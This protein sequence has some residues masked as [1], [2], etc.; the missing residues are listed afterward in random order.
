[1]NRTDIHRD[2]DGF[3]WD[4]LGAALREEA[5]SELEL[6]RLRRRVRETVGHHDVR[7]PA[8]RAAAVAATFSLV[9]LGLSFLAGSPS[10]SSEPVRLYAERDGRVVIEFADGKVHR[11]KKSTDPRFEKD[12]VVRTAKGRKL[13]DDDGHPA[14]GQVVFYRI[15]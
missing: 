14:P 8:L 11:V 13:V 3:R 4:A 2:A 5:P 7:R 9:A 15:D 1:M 12:I 10:G 6:A